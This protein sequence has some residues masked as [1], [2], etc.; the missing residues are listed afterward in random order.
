VIA[1]V[2]AALS[3]PAGGRVRL[4]LVAGGIGLIV[5]VIAAIIV[6]SAPPR[7]TATASP[8]PL[9]TPTA[10]PSPTTTP[11]PTPSEAA[12]PAPTADPLLGLDGR[13]TIL[14]LGSDY[15]PAHPGNRTD[16]IMIVSIDPT[17]GQTSVMSI[18]RDVARFPLPDGT[19]YAP[20]IN[21]LYQHYVA[22][23]GRATAGTEMKTVIGGALGVEIDSYAVIGFEGV[24][25]LID[26][27]SGVDV[28]LDHAV[29][30]PYYWVTGTQQGVYFPAGTNHLT[31][32]RALIFARTRKGDNDYER[33]RRQQ[34]LVAAT[35]AKVRAAG[36]STLAKLLTLAPTYVRTDLPLAQAADIMAIA[37]V[38]DLGTDQ[39]VV[40]G[41]RSYA[42][43]VSGSTDIILKMDVIR[44]LVARWM[45]PLP[46]SLAAGGSAAG[47][48]A[49][50]TGAAPT[51]PGPSGG[52][53]G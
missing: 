33:A 7:E 42:D 36:P 18:P 27:I 16:T 50:P 48:P 32:D 13:L 35:V 6:L 12:T 24:R 46:G 43:G 31:G 28:V 52:A 11:R 37:K 5:V 29:S 8:T 38:A 34:L 10:S 26:A 49:A 17:D 44:A 1:R 51:G 39:K 22:E 23:D 19:T 47:S 15:R 45:A 9:P 40:L 41:P 20:K 14:L 25:K 21:A 2:R 53:G 4:A 3:G 30:D